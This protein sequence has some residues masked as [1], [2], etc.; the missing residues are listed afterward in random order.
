MKDWKK[1]AKTAGLIVVVIG[2]V[3][4]GIMASRRPPVKM[5]PWF[6]AQPEEKIDAESFELFTKTREE[7]QKLQLSTGYVWKNPKTGKYTVVDE[8]VCI[9]CREKIPLPLVMLHPSH[10]KDPKY[11]FEYMGKYQSYKC[12]KCGHQFSSLPPQ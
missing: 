9:A 2:S 5:S 8:V 3:G 6:L 12:P 11:V 10:S 4:W 7:W 1:I